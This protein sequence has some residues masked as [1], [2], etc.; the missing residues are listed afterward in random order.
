MAVDLYIVLNTCYWAVAWLNMAFCHMSCQLREK[1]QPVILALWFERGILLVAPIPL[2]WL[3][4]LQECVK[5]S[6]NAVKL[7]VSA[8]KEQ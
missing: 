5:D 8:V 1:K 2:T 7:V 6:K 4:E 3:Q